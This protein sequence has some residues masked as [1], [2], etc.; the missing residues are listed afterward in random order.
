MVFI[1]G[2]AVVNDNNY[3]G[4]NGS[5]PATQA[6]GSVYLAP[7]PHDI[8]ILYYQ[9]TG[10]YGLNASYNGP[11]SGNVA[12][13]L[14]NAVLSPSS[15]TVGSLDG[16]GSVQLQSGVNLIAG[17]D[18]TSSTFGGVISGIGKSRPARA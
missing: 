13:N 16:S 4:Q 5:N 17:G 12:V 3:Q 15:M 14:P 11:D 9:G 8:T 18:N 10:G 2:N 7:G 6:T 1:D